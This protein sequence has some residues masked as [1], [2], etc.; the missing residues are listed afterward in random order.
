MLSWRHIIPTAP[1][2]LAT[3]S[4]E[5]PFILEETP[6]VLF[7]GGQTAYGTTKVQ[8]PDGQVTRVVSVPE[9]SRQPMM[10]LVN[11]HTLDVHP[12]YFDTS[13]E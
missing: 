5:D 13:L 3:Y 12:V 11:I 10:V 9:F 1:D 8:G 2:S 4:D 6:H 7:A